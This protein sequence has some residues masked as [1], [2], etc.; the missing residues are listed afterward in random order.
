MSVTRWWWWY[1]Y[2]SFCADC[3]V[4]T[5]SCRSAVDTPRWD[6]LPRLSSVSVAL[7]AC[8]YNQRCQLSSAAEFPG[9]SPP[10]PPPSYVPL[11]STQCSSLTHNGTPI[12]RSTTTKSKLHT[13]AILLRLDIFQYT[14]AYNTV[15][16][17]RDD[18]S[19]V[20]YEETEIQF[21]R[22]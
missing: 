10:P 14:T 12:I 19:L 17:C 18:W 11:H 2:K 20:Q 6:V 22:F 7:A 16:R 8:Q 9:L 5:S 13:V 15:W 4:P 1:W 3:R 21:P